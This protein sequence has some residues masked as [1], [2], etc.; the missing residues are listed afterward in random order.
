M[1]RDW[2]PSSDYEVGDV[3]TSSWENSSSRINL[4]VIGVNK[5]AGRGSCAYQTLI[6]KVEGHPW[7]EGVLFKRKS[8]T[9]HTAHYNYKRLN[10]QV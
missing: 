6:I 1:T 10:E 2:Q 4:V 7:S 9:K 5:N 8:L 3:L